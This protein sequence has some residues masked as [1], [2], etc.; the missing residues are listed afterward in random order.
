MNRR[1]A[2][3]CPK[4]LFESQET[5]GKEEKNRNFVGDFGWFLN[6][7]FNMYPYFYLDNQK[8]ER[9][10]RDALHGSLKK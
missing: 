10:H 1:E 7:M 6:E 4:P 9:S 3:T 5:A 8:C 2:D